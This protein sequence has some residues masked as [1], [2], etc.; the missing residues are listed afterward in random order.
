MFPRP[1]IHSLDRVLSRGQ[2][3]EKPYFGRGGRNTSRGLSLEIAYFGRRGQKLVA[4][5]EKIVAAV[6][7]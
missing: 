7:N 5:V 6:E 3:L 2:A 4:V 1:K